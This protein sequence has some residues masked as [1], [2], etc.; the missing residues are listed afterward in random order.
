[1]TQKPFGDL[2]SI[3]EISRKFSRV[4]GEKFSASQ[5]RP[6]VEISEFFIDVESSKFKARMQD[7]EVQILGYGRFI[8][9]TLMSRYSDLLS[10]TRRQDYF[11]ITCTAQD[12]N[13]ENFSFTCFVVHSE[14]PLHAGLP[15]FKS[16]SRCLSALFRDE[17]IRR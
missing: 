1:M 10:T 7:K 5:V 9:E 15:T 2:D 3:S 17:Q 4:F 16:L 14:S 11:T 12:D 13:Y 6:E 8:R